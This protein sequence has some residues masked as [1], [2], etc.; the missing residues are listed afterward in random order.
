MSN[1]TQTQIEAVRSMTNKEMVIAILELQQKVAELTA[2]LDVQRPKSESVE[3]TKDHAMR[4][5]NGDLK[6]KKHKDAAEALGLTYGQVYSCR[7]EFTFKD[8]H[9]ELKNSGFKNPWVKA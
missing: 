1:T 5:L 4:I 8:V 7:L 3:M 2:K 6:D 9:K